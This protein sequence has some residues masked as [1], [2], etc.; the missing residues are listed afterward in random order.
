MKDEERQSH[1]DAAAFLGGYI[2]GL[3]CFPFK[4]D[5]SE[6]Y[7]MLTDTPGSL[8]VYK[9]PV[10]KSLSSSKG[11]DEENIGI[12]QNILQQV[13]E[14]LTSTSTLSTQESLPVKSDILSKALADIDAEKMKNE[15]LL[16]GVGRVLVWLLVPVAAEQLKYGEL[17]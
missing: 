10:R 9:Q 7:N 17:F 2:L 11:S 8:F 15:E 3:P 16:L 6:A 4:A 13:K 12:F 1:V 14:K 5:V